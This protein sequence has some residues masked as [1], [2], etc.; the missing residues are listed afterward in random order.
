M[1]FNFQI[2]IVTG[3]FIQIILGIGVITWKARREV[4]EL[5][6]NISV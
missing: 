4:G 2:I 5:F 1:A 3:G 6:K